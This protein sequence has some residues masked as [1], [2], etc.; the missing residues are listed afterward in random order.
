MTSVHSDGLSHIYCIKGFLYSGLQNTTSTYIDV[1][2]M[3]SV[4]V[5][6]NNLRD[7]PFMTSAL[8][9]EGR[10]ENWQILWTNS[11]DR[12]PEMQTKGEGGSKIPK[13]LRTS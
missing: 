3:F 12:L 10:L 2:D 4:F 13:I 8:R 5:T 9:G 11:T 6:R 1:R 7:H